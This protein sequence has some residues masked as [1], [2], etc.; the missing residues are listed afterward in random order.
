MTRS[1]SAEIITLIKSLFSPNEFSEEQQAIYIDFF[2][3][4]DF[5]QA[6]EAIRLAWQNDT[7]EY[8]RFG[9]TPPP[10]L[11]QQYLD[12]IKQREKKTNSRQEWDIEL[13]ENEIIFNR[14]MAALISGLFRTKYRIERGLDSWQQA[15]LKDKQLVNWPIK[16]WEV[17]ESS[18]ENQKGALEES[19]KAF[20]K[21][22]YNLT[23]AQPGLEEDVPF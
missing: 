19:I 3:A 5:K 4:Y 23:F 22:L 18:N 16:I 11:F 1:Q 13:T 8:T 12:N 15:F 21:E 2:V 7:G 20:D 6:Q 10:G 17:W 9:K 14:K